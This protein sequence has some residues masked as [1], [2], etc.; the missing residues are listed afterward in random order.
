MIKK[1]SIIAFLLT[2]SA[3][4]TVSDA[5]YYWGDYAKTSYL[6]VNEPSEKSLRTH[7]DELTRIIEKSQEKNLKVPPGVYAELGYTLTKLGENDKA[8]VHFAAERQ[9]YPESGVFLNRLL[10]I[11]ESEGSEE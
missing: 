8:E 5:G 3:C 1:L 4:T 7:A 10:N 6:I 2:A 9:E 11:Q